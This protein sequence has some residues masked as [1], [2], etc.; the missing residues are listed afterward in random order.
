VT[1][2][3]TCIPLSEHID[4]LTVTKPWQ[5]N[6]K[7]GKD[8]LTMTV[9]LGVEVREPLPA[10]QVAE[11]EKVIASP[12]EAA[13]QAQER[14]ATPEP[15]APAHATA[16]KAAD[17]AE[18]EAAA[19]AD[20]GGALMSEED[21]DVRSAENDQGAVAAGVRDGDEEVTMVEEVTTEAPRD[22]AAA[23][24]AADAPE[25]EPERAATDAPSS[26][27]ALSGANSAP[28]SGGGFSICAAPLMVSAGM[29]LPP[30][31]QVAEDKSP[32]PKAAAAAPANDAPTAA[33]A[34]RNDGRA[35]REQRLPARLVD[36]DEGP[37]LAAPSHKASHKGSG[38]ESGESGEKSGDGAAARGGVSGGPTV[39]SAKDKARPHKKLANIYA[40][41]PNAA[42]GHESSACSGEEAGGGDA[43]AEAAAAG[44]LAVAAGKDGPSR[45]RKAAHAT[46][47]S[48]GDG[49]EAMAA[50]SSKVPAG[51]K[52]FKVGNYTKS[53][54]AQMAQIEAERAAAFA[55]HEMEA[56]G[57]FGGGG[58]MHEAGPQWS[59]F[60]GHPPPQGGMY[61]R[62]S[63]TRHNDG[64]TTWHNQYTHTPYGGENRAG[65]AFAGNQPQQMQAYGAQLGAASQPNGL[66]QSSVGEIVSRFYKYKPPVPTGRMDPRQ[67]LF[68][69]NAMQAF[70]N[71]SRGW[72]PSALHHHGLVAAPMSARPMME[73]GWGS[74]AVGGG[75]GNHATTPGAL[76]RL[77][78]GNSADNMALRRWK[79]NQMQ[80]GTA[81]HQSPRGNFMVDPS[82]RSLYRPPP[83]R[84][85]YEK[86]VAKNQFQLS[87]L[88]DTM[89]R[90]RRVVSSITEPV[91]SQMRMVIISRAQRLLDEICTSVPQ[92]PPSEHAPLAAAVV[93]VQAWVQRQLR[94][95]MD[96]L[97]I[98]KPMTKLSQQL[99]A[100][101]KKAIK[102]K[103]DKGKGVAA[104]GAAG[105]DNRRRITGP[106][107]NA[108]GTSGGGAAAGAPAQ[109]KD[110]SAADAA[111][112]SAP[113]AAAAAPSDSAAAPAGAPAAAAETAGRPREND[114]AA[115]AAAGPPCNED[116]NEDN[117]METE[118]AAGV[119]P[120][121]AASGRGD[122]APSSG[123]TP[124]AGK[125]DD[126][127]AT[128]AGDGPPATAE[129]NGDE[130]AGAAAAAGA[131][132]EAE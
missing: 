124:T 115:A 92:I 30:G 60:G 86:T 15:P 57:G 87:K 6:L 77:D 16:T 66:S 26:K 89:E 20:E 112:G 31:E 7:E 93:E 116:N 111:E 105:D 5:L 113:R 68:Q 32:S 44:L 47:V 24:P 106:P 76:E 13:K 108:A 109:I 43:I 128:D 72:D 100:K 49:A 64:T 114:A 55:R 123:P 73:Q 53:N 62:Q 94:E 122:D 61:G 121:P 10:T 80:H 8:V 23:K 70:R 27:S 84:E 3:N 120:S 79:N 22:A 65:G 37:Q 38:K 131:G 45:K 117:E 95:R 9:P 59:M 118:D 2:A 125:G 107:S 119:S 69:L 41:A 46:R 85:A 17:E 42:L 54:S 28:S 35:K 40:R 81:G 18:A 83:T 67:S 11:E 82:E 78:A 52:P 71:Q 14:E 12:V 51:E 96:E 34:V 33:P 97:L 103:A 132:E 101:P 56:R 39:D 29:E 4:Q 63:Y 36:S 88:C 126:A 99:T 129:G 127:L 104:G 91:P 102:D 110:K 25:P 75:F 21:D 48:K 50:R 1:W 74:G 19:V 130:A 98:T 58:S 90:L